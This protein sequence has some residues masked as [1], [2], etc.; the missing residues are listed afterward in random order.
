MNNI[1]FRTLQLFPVNS[2]PYGLTYAQWTMK[3]WSW[4][5]KIPIQNS[6]VFDETGRNAY[7]DQDDPH[8][9]FLCQTYGQNRSNPSRHVLVQKGQ[10]L[11]MP[12]I[13]W[14]SIAPEDGQTDNDLIL[15]A[16]SKM[17]SISDLTMIVNG[18][19]FTADFSQY[20]VQSKPFY[21][22]VPKE[23]ILTLQP[24]TKKIVSDGYWILTESI[25]KSMQLTTFGSCSAGLT[26]IGVN[27]DITIV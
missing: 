11:F 1:S 25:I 12:L 17:N 20:R 19:Q 21:V 24:G 26:K 8:V 9:F 4:L 22:D 14:I 6:P 13:N 16:Q 7:L 3:W 27:Y 15:K 18:D 5:L 10:S 23:N 2:R